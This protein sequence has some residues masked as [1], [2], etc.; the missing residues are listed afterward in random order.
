MHTDAE[1]DDELVAERA[2]LL[3][4]EESAGS[5]DAEVQAQ[6][7]LEDSLARTD[8]PEGTRADSQQTPGD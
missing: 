6:L 8:D 4:E 7:I 5:V 3:P 1:R 2:H